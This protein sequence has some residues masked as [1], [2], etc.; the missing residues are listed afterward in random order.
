MPLTPFQRRKLARMFSVYDLDHDGAIR[1]SDYTHRV[2]AIARLRGWTH[3]S[4][5][6]ERNLRF[7]LMEWEALCESADIDEDGQVSRDEFLRYAEIFLDDRDAVRSFARGD[8]QL[9]FDAMD[10]DGDNRITAEEYRA[11]LDVCGVDPSAADAFFAYADLDLDGM[12]TRVEMS[13]A[14]EEYLL[15]ENPDAA[16]NFLFGPLEPES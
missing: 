14:V 9:L 12:M 4:P 5:E 10:V 3:H 16:G 11:Y 2:E 6:Y 8:A 13:H 7:A 1:R 15:S